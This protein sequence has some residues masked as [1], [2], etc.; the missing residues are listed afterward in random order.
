MNFTLAN[1]SPVTVVID[2]KSYAI[3]RARRKFWGEWASEIDAK[4]LE[5]ATAGMSD[6][7]RARW[8][9]INQVWC[10][11][12][13]DLIKLVN[14]LDGA[15]RVI[16]HCMGQGGIEQAVIDRV[17]D[18]LGPNERASLAFTLAAII[19]PA[20]FALAA[21]QQNQNGDGKDKTEAGESDPL[22]RSTQAAAAP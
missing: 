4:K 16:A 1:K 13:D 11:T 5:A 15:D 20:A 21:Q 3:P 7:D 6:E 12:H 22:A 10:T 14:T 8:V 17:V 2:G 18:E 19:D 9:H